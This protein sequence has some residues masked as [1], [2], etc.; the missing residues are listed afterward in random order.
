M[1]GQKLSLANMLNLTFFNYLC[2]IWFVWLNLISQTIYFNNNN[3][4]PTP[5]AKN[6]KIT[7]LFASSFRSL[8]IFNFFYFEC[9]MYNL[10]VNKG[11]F[12]WTSINE[13][14]QKRTIGIG[15][16]PQQK[17][18]VDIASYLDNSFLYLM[19]GSNNGSL[20][21]RIFFEQIID[22]HK[23]ILNDIGRRGKL[24]TGENR[25]Y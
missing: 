20:A 23:K 7:N 13:I 14:L 15:Q 18:P 8:Y 19:E 1:V 6:I 16:R 22:G 24:P 5:N 4:R 11:F 2:L 9:Q 17:V 3:L 10:S 21:N 25:K 12:N